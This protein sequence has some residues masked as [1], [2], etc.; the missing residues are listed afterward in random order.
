MGDLRLG[1]LAGGQHERESD[2]SQSNSTASHVAAHFRLGRSPSDHR[3]KSERND[4]AF[5][6]SAPSGRFDP[7]ARLLWCVSLASS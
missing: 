3:T 7:S 6:W 4:P 5:T 1:T 2:Q